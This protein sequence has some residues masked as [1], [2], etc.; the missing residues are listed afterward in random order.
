LSDVVIT[1]TGLICSLGDRADRIHAALSAGTTAF[2][3][4]S[5]FGDRVGA[6]R[7]AE[8]SG[9]APRDYLGGRNLRP[10][11]RTGQLAAVAAQLALA[12]SG[13]TGALLEKQD[14]GLVLG[15]TFGGVR[16]IAEFD[17]RAMREGPEYA[18]PLDFANTVIN[19][20]A[21]GVAI[22]HKLRGINSTIAAGSVSGLHAIGYAAQLI[23][24]R[25]AWALLAGGAEELCFESY[26][27]A[28]RAGLLAPAGAGG[29]APY[30]RERQGYVP[31]EG[32]GFLVL[33]SADAAAARGA[34]ILGRVEAF[35]AAYDSRRFMDTS[36]GENA[37]TH[38]IARV[39]AAAPDVGAVM[40]SGSGSPTLD[41]REAAALRA[42]L[43]ASGVRP[44]V[45]TMKGHAGEAL[46]ASGAL[47]AIIA[48]EA[49]RC[50]SLPG[51]AG[52]RQPDAGADLDFVTGAPRP[53][54]TPRAL[55]TAVAREGNCCALTLSA[56]AT[57]LP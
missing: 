34:R 26:L 31:G 22:W 51:I 19:A 30:D 33:E 54:A 24:A 12:D 7:V 14:V 55:L 41:A 50:R 28:A 47:Q 18:S 37:L 48:L 4:S 57:T 44:P 5:I 45:T 53:I 38:V 52:L 11:D 36:T 1:G 39:L 29:P 8:V 43:G 56:R 35:S 42:A 16:T 20:A 17:R 49:I 46:G 23:R 6:H 40:A 21:G 25:R 15:T 9:F 32:A 3:P 27:G 13:W 10:L 2:G